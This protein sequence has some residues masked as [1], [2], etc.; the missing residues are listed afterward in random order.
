MYLFLTIFLITLLFCFVLILFRRHCAIRKV[1]A[2]SC[3]EKCRLLQ[4][5]LAP[6]GYYYCGRQDVISTRNDAWQRQAGYTALFDQAALHFNMVFD[7]LPIYFDYQ[8]RTWL[9]E[10]WKGQYGINAGAEVGV[11]YADGLVTPSERSTAHFDAVSDCD[12]LPISFTLCHHSQILASMSDRSWWLTAFL[13]GKFAT[14]SQL[15]LDISITFPNTE[16]QRCFLNA[17]RQSANPH[18]DYRCH[19]LTVRIHYAN[20]CPISPVCPEQVSLFRRLRITWAQFCNKLLCALYCFLARP[21]HTTLDRVVFLYELLPFLLRRM[22]KHLK[23][24]IKT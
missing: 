7:A 4:E 14:P 9:I 24:V 3:T 17:L 8:G 19:N 15:S 6:F 22:L 1:C 5:L 11:Y 12:R 10:V 16:M 20:G 23:G 18:I 13:V 21:F 2:M